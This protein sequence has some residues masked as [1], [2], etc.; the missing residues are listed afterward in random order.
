STREYEG[1]PR[2]TQFVHDRS[3]LPARIQNELKA[4]VEGASADGPRRHLPIFRNGNPARRPRMEPPAP[5]SALNQ[6]L[7][8]VNDPEV[9][10]VRLYFDPAIVETE[11]NDENRMRMIWNLNRELTN[12]DTDVVAGLG[13]ELDL[14]AESLRAILSSGSTTVG[15]LTRILGYVTREGD[16]D[17]Y[18]LGKSEPGFDP[19]PLDILTVAL[20]EVWINEHN[21]AISLDP[22][23]ADCF[24]P[25]NV[26][27]EEISEK[28]RNTR[29][30]EIM[31]EADYRMKHVLFKEQS[32]EA[33][34]SGFQTTYELLQANPPPLGGTRQARYWLNPRSTAGADV[35]VN[36]FEG[37]TVVYFES[38][39]KVLTEEME[40]AKTLASSSPM[41]SADEE[42]A[43]LFTNHYDEIA[44]CYPEFRMLRGV[45]DATKLAVVLRKRGVSSPL[46]DEAAARSV[47]EVPIR[48]T[49]DGLGPLW[50]EGT[51]YF[52]GGGC[53]TV[54][55]P[56]T[57]IEVPLVRS[58]SQEEPGIL[59][60]S[61]LM[62]GT[63]PLT[64][65]AALDLFREAEIEQATKEIADNR[66]RDAIDRLTN[67]IRRIEKSGDTS[68]IAAV[69]PQRAVAWLGIGETAKALEDVKNIDV[70][71]PVVQGL[72]GILKLFNND[73]E[74]AYRDVVA[75]AEADPRDKTILSNKAMV[76]MMTLRLDDAGRSLTRLISVSPGDPEIA[77]MELNLK[78]LRQLGPVKAK[79]RVRQYISTP[80]AITLALEEGQS[81]GISGHVNEGIARIEKALDEMGRRIKELPALHLEER[82]WMVLVSL[83]DIKKN[84][85]GLSEEDE[86]K[87]NKLIS[88]LIARR[89]DWPSSWLVKLGY[90]TDP[91][92]NDPKDQ[93]ALFRK[94]VSTKVDSDPLLSEMALLFGCDARGYYGMQ[95]LPAL[96][97]AV[98]KHRISADEGIWFIDKVG[99]YFDTGPELH[100][101][102]TFRRYVSLLKTIQQIMKR[103]G[104]TPEK[105][106]D[107]KIIEKVERDVRKAL[108]DDF[109]EQLS[110]QTL[111]KNLL[112]MPPPRPGS[113]VVPLQ[114]IGR[115]FIPALME[116]TSGML[117]SIFEDET[118]LEE[119]RNAAE[120]V[121]ASL[122]HGIGMMDIEWGSVEA[123]KRAAA[124]MNAM[125]ALYA[126]SI[127]ATISR[128][129]DFKTL[130]EDAK[131]GL[132]SPRDFMTS[133]QAR[134]EK[135]VAEDDQASPGL[136]AFTIAFGQTLHLDGLK[137]VR[138]AIQMNEPAWDE[139]EEVRARWTLRMEEWETAER[140]AKEGFSLFQNLVERMPLD[141]PI[142]V[143]MAQQLLTS[144]EKMIGTVATGPDEV[145]RLIRN[146]NETRARLELRLTVAMRTQ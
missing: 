128:Q 1:Y 139:N 65:E 101:L 146:L 78:V 53:V 60:L 67:L 3:S 75:A 81:L 5:S 103:H 135:A 99:T 16:D 82:A 43:R 45:F 132:L 76:E 120:E 41:S 51:S 24:G 37:S 136:K 106:P 29:Y 4:L 7:S 116:Q 87:K 31:L 49:Y 32:Y 10:G 33:R 137:R 100:V 14:R 64:P 63:I 44:A 38:D 96:F 144:F 108:G 91:A 25:Q 48:E 95:F 74:G 122:L 19:V 71:I 57:G 127:L 89:P 27:L 88:R 113:G 11:G 111:Q 13:G 34:I 117:S 92:G 98:G 50:I 54:E 143:L 105:R 102:K 52:I 79:E 133:T 69:L 115:Y 112:L 77:M 46:L 59:R 85:E 73:L 39:I 129:P 118:P 121:R 36:H 134:F 93:L 2:Y 22:D 114:V 124:G 40:D 110:V 68:M 35:F 119:T 80:F 62:P 56:S 55:E 70:E 141:R 20:Q 28:N 94:A 58:L 66:H 21:P 84:S 123:M 18:I 15:M 47:A 17:L 90:G 131:A 140:E 9:G 61:L 109:E 97:D 138:E 30:V 107:E 8:A 125:Y 130:E 83:Y 12:G 72:R 23:P 86:E 6:N 26:R 126:T 104:A 42:A 142:D 145:S